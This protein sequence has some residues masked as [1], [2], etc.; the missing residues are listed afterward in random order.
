MDD[1]DKPAA[2]KFC[3]PSVRSPAKNSRWKHARS[4]CCLLVIG[5]RAARLCRAAGAVD[6]LRAPEGP[7]RSADGDAHGA[8]HSRRSHQCR[9]GRRQ[10]GRALRHARRRLVSGRPDHAG[11]IDRDRRQRAARPAVSRRAG[12]QS[13]S[14]SAAA[15]TSLSRSRTAAAP[16]S[17]TMCGSGRC[18]TRATRS[19]R[20]GSAMRRFDRGVG[21]SHYTGAVTH[22]IAAD[23]DAEREFLVGRP[24]D[25]GMVETN[26]QVTGI[27]P[28]DRR[29]QWRRRSL[30]HRRRGL[31]LAAGRG[32]READRPAEMIASPAATEIKDQIWQAVAGCE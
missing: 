21:V 23:L 12:Q 22:H 29:P 15:R 28:D 10:Q 17:A 9:A 1:R 25:A 16:T 26:Y 20:S 24:R 32:L 6:P 18:S 27:G 31:D 13:V 2:C 8:G 7:R 3:D 19:G 30:F 11:I 14:I 4:C 5:L